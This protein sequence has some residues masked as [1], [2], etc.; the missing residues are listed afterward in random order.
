MLKDVK[1]ANLEETILKTTKMMNEYDIGS[2]VVTKE[3]QPVGIVT[4]RD[5]LKRLFSKRKD[6]ART[7]LHE[8]MSKPL[9]TIKPHITVIGAAQLMIKRKVKKLIVKN[10]DRLLGIV[11]LTDLIPLLRNGGSIKRLPLKNAAKRVKR[12]FGMYTIQ[13]DGYARDAQ[14]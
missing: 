14:S 5:I 8:I 9:V 2:V 6:S 3:G 13:K 12:I 10:G 1:H 11:T 4:E 7:K